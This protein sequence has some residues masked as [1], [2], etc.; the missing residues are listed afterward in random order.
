MYGTDFG[1]AAVAHVIVGSIVGV[2][3][4]LGVPGTSYW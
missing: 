3:S 4:W 1:N 2:I